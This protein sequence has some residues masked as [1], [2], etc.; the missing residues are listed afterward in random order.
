MTTEQEV[1]PEDLA[2]KLPPEPVPH[3]KFD[4]N[5]FFVGIVADWESPYTVPVLPAV[6]MDTANARWNGREWVVDNSR[7]T[8]LP[9]APVYHQYGDDGFYCGWTYNRTLPRTVALDSYPILPSQARWDGNTWVIDLS[10]ESADALRQL[11]A[12]V[13][14]DLQKRLDELAVSWGY[15]SMLSLVSYT[16]SKTNKFAREAQAGSDWRDDVWTYAASSTATTIEDFMAGVP[17]APEK[18]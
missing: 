6:G 11:R 5:G 8:V 4:F 18:P 7:S 13:A 15:D 10:R 17:E 1:K 12:M 3:A 9:T 2:Q 14:I 16:T